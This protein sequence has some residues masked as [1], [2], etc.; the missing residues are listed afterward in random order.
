LKSSRSKRMLETQSTN[1][2]DN[3]VVPG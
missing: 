2:E 3:P 1:I